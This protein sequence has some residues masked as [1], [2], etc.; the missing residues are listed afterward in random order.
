M[1]FLCLL[2]FSQQSVVLTGPTSRPFFQ[3]VLPHEFPINLRPHT[4]VVVTI[5]PSIPCILLTGD[6]F[7]KFRY[8]HYNLF[9][10]H[11]HG[12]IGHLRSGLL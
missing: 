12:H 6:F 8:A 4:F 10:A 2:A 1:Y 7:R 9:I 3:I 5:C 11:F